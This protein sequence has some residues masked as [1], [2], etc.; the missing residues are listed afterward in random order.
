MVD[1]VTIDF[2]L[3]EGMQR[4]GTTEHAER[5]EYTERSLSDFSGFSGSED[6]QVDGLVYELYGLREEVRAVGIAESLKES[7]DAERIRISGLSEFSA[8]AVQWIDGGG[9][10]GSGGAESLNALRGVSP[11]KEASVVSGVSVGSM[12]QRTRRLMGW[13]MSCMG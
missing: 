6:A 4:G 13:C 11:L 3:H 5:N 7:E 12:V 2:T 8:S 9:D 1:C 10:W